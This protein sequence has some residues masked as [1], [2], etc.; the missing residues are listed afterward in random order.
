MR[1]YGGQYTRNLEYEITIIDVGFET[2][3]NSIA[4]GKNF[5]TQEYY[6]NKNQFYVMEWN[7]RV[8]KP[9]QYKRHIYENYIDYQ[10]G[11]NYGLDVNYKLYNY[12]KFVEYKHGE[13][14]LLTRR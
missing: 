7:N 11:I 8:S 1:T 14:F 12:F 5:Y 6:E 2:Y 10:P 3:L 9:F 4:R 13:R